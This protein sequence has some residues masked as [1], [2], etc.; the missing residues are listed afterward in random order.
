VTHDDVLAA[1]RQAGL[2]DYVA[3]L[4][5]G[6]DT[7]IHA[8][9]VS[10]GEAQRIGTARGLAGKPKLLILDEPTS[11][12]DGAAEQAFEQMLQR[13]KQRVSLVVI[14]HRLESL[15]SVDQI[16]V[17][18]GGRVEA[19]GPFEEVLRENEW[20]RQARAMHAT[21]SVP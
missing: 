18:H 3:G 16:A 1:I 4:P 11:A 20:L 5:Q 13:I 12:I 7:P 17:I 10:G 8:N 15:K 19:N 6:I 21:P 9:A 14:A 2:E